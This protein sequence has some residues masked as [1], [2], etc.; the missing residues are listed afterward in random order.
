MTQESRRL[1]GRTV[2]GPR[3]RRRSSKLNVSRRDETVRTRDEVSSDS[4]R[5][6]NYRRYRDPQIST[7]TRALI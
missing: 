3:D 4:R 5:L 2:H 1:R 6:R 7:S